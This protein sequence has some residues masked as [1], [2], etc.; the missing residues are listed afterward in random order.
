[1]PDT[2]PATPTVVAFHEAA[3]RVTIEVWILIVEPLNPKIFK[4]GFAQRGFRLQ[5]VHELGA[6]MLQIKFT[7]GLKNL[8]CVFDI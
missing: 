3:Q 4:I 8:A 6:A 5:M 1:M 2:N 7:F